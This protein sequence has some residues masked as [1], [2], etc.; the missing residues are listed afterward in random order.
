MLKLDRKLHLEVGLLDIS[1][2]S[3]RNTVC[4][5]PDVGTV[6]TSSLESDCAGLKSVSSKFLSIQNFTI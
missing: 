2:A 1:T 3:S 6:P 5:Q 4:E